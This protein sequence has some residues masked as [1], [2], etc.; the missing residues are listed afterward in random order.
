MLSYAV[1]TT[2]HSSKIRILE[3]SFICLITFGP[4]TSICK[5][6]NLVPPTNPE[7]MLH[8]FIAIEGPHLIEP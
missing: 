7:E 8:K 4:R 3:A 2:V 5:S 6:P 1:H